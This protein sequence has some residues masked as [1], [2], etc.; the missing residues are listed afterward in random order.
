MRNLAVTIRYVG[1]AYHGFQVQKNAI[2]ICEAFQDALE[3]VLGERCDIKGCSRTDAGVHA[4]KYVLSLKTDNSIDTRGFVFAMNAALPDDIAVLDCKE[5]DVDFHARYSCKGKRY[6]YKI[7][8]SR[9]P[10]PFLQNRSYRCP[11]K[12]DA[13]IMNEAAKCFI[14]T[15]DF[16][17]F[18]TLDNYNR[19]KSK[20]RTIYDCSAERTGDVIT[21]SITGDGFLY[22]MVRIVCGTLLY[23]ARGKI[24]PEELPEIIRL[25]DRKLAGP[26]LPP[27][28]LYLDEIFYEEIT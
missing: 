24:A 10:D 28:G 13:E 9:L 25:G 15:H 21:I 5:V 22:N 20:V 23:T 12:L 18:C 1:T 7:Y 3:R 8:N 26:T 6:I 27:Q 4:N 17:A 2:T 16:S 14:G 11:V 19:D